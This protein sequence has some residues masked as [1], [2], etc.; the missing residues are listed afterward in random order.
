MAGRRGGVVV[1]ISTEFNN[2]G[3]EQANKQL[4][5]FGKTVSR[6]F[7]GFGA[8]IAG[9]F[10]FGAITEQIG[11][12]IDAGSRL[13][14][15]AG[16]TAA[17]FGDSSTAMRKWAD[18]A[19]TSLG[20]S[21]SQALD[22]ANRFAASGKQMG[23]TTSEL[24]TFTQDMTT[25]AAD[26]AA[27]FGGTVTDA[28]TA[29]A[30]TFR[31]EFDP[32]EKYGLA[33]RATTVEAKAA[34]LGF[35]KVNGAF[36]QAAKNTAV[37]ELIREQNKLNGVVGAFNREGDTYAGTMQRI[38][39]SVENAQTTIGTEFI[40]AIS[41]VTTSLG[42]ANGLSRAIEDTGDDIADFV[43]GVT[44]AVTPVTKLASAI[45]LINDNMNGND[46]LVSNF[47]ALGKWLPIFG[48]IAGVYEGLINIGGHVRDAEAELNDEIA[49]A[50]QMRHIYNPVVTASAAAHRDEMYY[51]NK[52]TEAIN[53]L[54]GAME[55]RNSANRSIIG[56]NIRMRQLRAQGPQDTNGDGRISMDER[57]S[58]GLEYA[59]VVDQKYNALKDQGKLK[60]AQALLENSRAYIGGVVSPRFANNILGTP[61]ELPSAIDARSRAKSQAGANKWAGNMRDVYNTFNISVS[62]KTP[63][64]TVQ[65]TA[66]MKR[67]AALD[68][69][70][71]TIDWEAAARRAAAR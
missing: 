23:L 27:M 65:M 71:S 7:M 1:P 37:A 60:R 43:A 20:L 13:Q 42:G 52:A 9:A 17:M 69:T 4:S 15:S 24:V 16:A 25:Q 63:E 22:A 21:S 33:L 66:R 53:A 5:L 31:G 19:A 59:G 62:T 8:S 58:F 56:A 61:P 12:M 14:Q 3:L 45:G 34:A 54:N 55:R 67:L 36:T 28:V 38:Q 30:A 29:L 18:G 49:R 11:Q 64:E 41:K 48:P 57:K 70:S 10:A 32:A 51:A 40:N 26:L 6:Q 46:G 2:R 47:L 35:Q 44:W 39:A 50:I 68:R